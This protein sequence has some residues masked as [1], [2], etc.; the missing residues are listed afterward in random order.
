MPG[1]AAATIEN[2]P[3]STSLLRIGI[4]SPKRYA[5]SVGDY[6]VEPF[7]PSTATQVPLKAA[8]PQRASIVRSS[9]TSL[10]LPP[11]CSCATSI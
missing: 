1:N 8:V 4:G 6:W 10:M 3:A 2:L 9:V 11:A 5:E 7:V